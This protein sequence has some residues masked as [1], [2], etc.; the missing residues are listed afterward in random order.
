MYQ[1]FLFTLMIAG[2]LTGLFG[3]YSVGMRNVVVVP[4][5]PEQPVEDET[6]S[7]AQRP[8]EN[9][10][11]ATT[12][13]PHQVWA[14]NS[15]Y[16]LRAE[17]AFVYTESWRSVVENN[18]RIR[19]EKFAM[20]WISLDKDGQERAVSI[21]SERALLE[22]AFAFDERTPNPGRVVRAMLEGDVEITGPDGLSV[23]GHNFIF[24]EAELNLYT[25]NPVSFRFQSHRGSASRM[26]MKLIPAEG[27][28]GKDRPHVYGV[29]SIQLI[30][31]PSLPE[32]SHVRLE[33]QSPQGDELKPINVK[34]AG[35]MEYTV[36]TNTAILTKDVIVW[37]GPKENLDRLDCYKL[38]MQFSPKKPL[39]E[40]PSPESTPPAATG[41]KRRDNEYQHVERDLEFSWLLAESQ[42][43]AEGRPGEQVK[44]VSA[45]QQAKAYMGRLAYNAETHMLSMGSDKRDR[46]VRVT[47]KGSELKVPSIEAQIHSAPG[48]QLR[49]NSLFCL[50]AGELKFVDEKTGKLAFVATWQKQLSKKTDPETNLDLVELEE[51]AHFG[52]PEQGTGLIAELI[53]IWLVPFDLS[54]TLQGTERPQQTQQPE[55]KR[56]LAQQGVALQSPQLLIKRTNELDIVFDEPEPGTPAGLQQATTASDPTSSRH[57]G[58]PYPVG[59]ASIPAGNRRSSGSASEIP[60]E[61]DSALAAQKTETVPMKPIIVSADQI[62]VRMRRVSGRQEPQVVAVHSAGK[63]VISQERVPGEKPT[64]LDGDRVDLHNESL[65]HEVIHVFGSPARIRDQRFKIEGK[66]IHLDRGENRAWVSGSGRLQLAIPEQSAVPGL[67]GSANRELHVR[68]DESMIF[69]GL[70]AK[71]IGRVEAKLGLASMD[72]EQLKLQLMQRLGFQTIS[73]EIKP[74]IRFIH[75]RENVKFKNATYSEKKLIDKYRGQVGEFAWNHATGEVIAQGPGEIQVWRRQKTGGSVSAQRDTIQANRPIP[76]EISEWD[77]TCIQFEGKL[78]GRVDGALNGNSHK[79]SATI[80]DRVKVTHGPVR[81]PNDEVNPDELPSKSGTIH[82]DRLQFVNHPVSDQNPVEYR[83]LVGLGNAEVEGQVEGRSYTASADEISYDGSK[84]LYVLRAHGKQNAR[85]TEIGSGNI[86]GQRIEFNPTTR[87]LKVDRATGGQWGQSR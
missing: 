66:E 23:I 28:P 16:M 60:D 30:A 10:R 34:C 41:E 42:F 4:V 1:R 3:V 43:E 32:N 14:A 85:L 12:H 56:L 86:P 49:L 27:L 18:K 87:F 84:G 81:M 59:F 69:D 83:E 54:P 13:V 36:V 22:F 82:C 53:K 37:T 73:S 47:Q 24:D 44:I 77:Y 15:K 40:E 79:Q 74:E 35:D 19:F 67:D 71:F 26:A 76:V 78:K 33:I 52:Q 50:G 65:N 63:V 48:E 2:S 68:W 7:Q 25:L 58:E 75:C 61:N 11:V 8:A 5:R 6:Y 72:C 62:G 70:D 20:V 57:P 31:N 9:V 39:T 64:T 55:P 80:E 45:S 17:Q 29:E 51:N 38:T 21:V 46:F